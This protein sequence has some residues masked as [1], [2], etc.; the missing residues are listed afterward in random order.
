MK[1][2]NKFDLSIPSVMFIMVIFGLSMACSREEP[3]VIDQKQTI[4]VTDGRLHFSSEELFRTTIKQLAEKQNNLAEWEKQFP[5]FTSMRTAFKQLTD[6]DYQK[7]AAGTRSPYQDIVA[8]IGEGEEREAVRVISDG[9]LSTLVSKDGFMYIA[10]KAYKF[11]WDQMYVIEDFTAEKLKGM[12]FETGQGSSEYKTIPIEHR[13]VRTH[14]QPLSSG[15]IA[16]SKT[17]IQNYDNGGRNK[18]MAGDIDYSG[19]GF[20]SS[21]TVMTKHQQR[22]LGVWYAKNTG[23]VQAAGTA[24]DAVSSTT[25]S[26]NT[27]REFND[28]Y[29]QF[30]FPG[31]VYNISTGHEALCDDNNVRYCEQYL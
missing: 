29:C 28:G 13:I 19:S 31:E 14:N 4:Q 15:K 25:Y 30:S 10:N 20:Y 11:N 7:I 24:T 27:G 5:G 12:N 2:F 9:I 3:T 26:Y 21:V 18:R 1:I 8:I 16:A 6:E 23:Y 22:I 17:C